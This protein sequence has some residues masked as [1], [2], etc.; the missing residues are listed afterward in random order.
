MNNTDEWFNLLKETHDEIFEYRKI[1]GEKITIFPELDEPI[2]KNSKSYDAMLKKINKEGVEFNSILSLMKV[3]HSLDSL[4][5]V[6]EKLIASLTDLRLISNIESELSDR[7]Y[8]NILEK[9]KSLKNKIELINKNS[10]NVTDEGI[11]KIKKDEILKNNLSTIEKAY[12]DYNSVNVTRIFTVVLETFREN[13]KDLVL[14]HEITEKMKD[15]SLGYKNEKYA[16]KPFSKHPI[17]LMGLT[18]N[19]VPVNSQMVPKPPP[20]NG[21]CQI[22][23]DNTL[24]LATN[25]VIYRLDDLLHGKYTTLNRLHSINKDSA[26]HSATIQRIPVEKLS[27]SK[28]FEKINDKADIAVV[29]ETFDSGKSYR[30]LSH[31]VPTP[32]VVN[33]EKGPRP[34]VFLYPK[35]IWEALE[36]KR[37]KVF[38]NKKLQSVSEYVDAK[39]FFGIHNIKEML[40]KIQKKQSTTMP[41][42]AMLL[43]YYRA[44]KRLDEIK[45]LQGSSKGKVADPKIEIEEPLVSHLI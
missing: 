35:N 6:A 23:I 16:T 25:I 18:F 36:A 30:K 33:M 20:E 17:S 40:N 24:K 13:K 19:L 38:L 37:D 22:F 7:Y 8:K 9:N 11:L 41:R 42:E 5:S 26:I 32:T 3:I 4:T 45:M 39:P 2:E 27:T 31:M 14:I 21:V 12:S 29:Y 44:Q 43:N 34:R 15:L 28:G 1:A 10:R